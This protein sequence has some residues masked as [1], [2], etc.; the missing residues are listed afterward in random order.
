[1]ESSTFCNRK[2]IPRKK[3]HYKTKFTAITTGDLWFFHQSQKK[4]TKNIP[5]YSIKQASKSMNHE[6]DWI[7]GA[8]TYPLRKGIFGFEGTPAWKEIISPN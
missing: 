6:V 8:F 7:G 3:I 1:V 4:L 2:E 5:Y